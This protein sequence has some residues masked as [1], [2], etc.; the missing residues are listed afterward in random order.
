MSTCKICGRT[1]LKWRN[2]NGK[3]ILTIP[4]SGIAHKC[5]RKKKKKTVKQEVQQKTLF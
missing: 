2:F 1:G 3:W 4:E 5:V